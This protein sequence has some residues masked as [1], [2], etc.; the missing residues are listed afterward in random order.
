MYNYNLAPLSQEVA[1]LCNELQ[2]LNLSLAFSFH[3][4]INLSVTTNQPTVHSTETDVSFGRIFQ[5]QQ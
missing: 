2:S 3:N 5:M 4:S 1:I